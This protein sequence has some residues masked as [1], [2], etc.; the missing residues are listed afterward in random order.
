MTYG[1]FFLLH[2]ILNETSLACNPLCIA[3]LRA[4]L[5]SGPVLQHTAPPSSESTLLSE[6]LY[7]FNWVCLNWVEEDEKGQNIIK[8]SPAR[9]TNRFNTEEKRSLEGGLFFSPNYYFYGA[10]L[11]LHQEWDFKPPCQSESL[12][13]SQGFHYIQRDKRNTSLMSLLPLQGTLTAAL[14]QNTAPRL[15]SWFHTHHLPL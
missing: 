13:R 6:K 2:F 8:S 9:Y 10:V 1:L 14:T 5:R 4:K 15:C 3:E 7:Q 12:K 11:A